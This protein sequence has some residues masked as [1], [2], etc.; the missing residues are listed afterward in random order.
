MSVRFVLIIL[1][2]IHSEKKNNIV[3]G[4]CFS[5]VCVCVCVV[6]TTGR[7]TYNRFRKKKYVYITNSGLSKTTV[8]RLVNFM[9]VCVL[10]LGTN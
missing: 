2:D 10:G 1:L 5:G 9:C 4:E 8:K 7:A 3:D 6:G